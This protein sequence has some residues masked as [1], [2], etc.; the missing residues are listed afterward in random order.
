MRKKVAV[1][2]KNQAFNCKYSISIINFL[3]EFKRAGDFSCI[4]EGS[5][6]WLYA[7]FMNGSVLA[8]IKGQMAL[9]SYEATGMRGL[10]HP[11]PR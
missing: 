1:R 9:S 5:V 2:M 6:I 7:E 8:A 3:T 10:S 11:M 4:L